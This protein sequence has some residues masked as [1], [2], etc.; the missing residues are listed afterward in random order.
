[1]AKSVSS[2]LCLVEGGI[3]VTIKKVAGGCFSVALKNHQ[4]TF[5]GN[6]ESM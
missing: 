2:T 1:L 4:Y 6:I 5:L 3:S